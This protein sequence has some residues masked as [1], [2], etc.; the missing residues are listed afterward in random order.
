MRELLEAERVQSIVGAFFDVYN[1]FGYG[2]S[3]SI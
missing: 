1:Y 2:V 3:E